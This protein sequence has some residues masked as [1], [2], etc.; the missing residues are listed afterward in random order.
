MRTTRTCGRL[1]LTVDEAGAA[2][3]FF[4]EGDEQWAGFLKGAKA[5][6][7][8]GGGVGVAVDG[9]IGGDDE[10][11]LVLEARWRP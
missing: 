1:G 6:V 11:V 9:G 4:D 5:V 3:A 10:H 8:A 7:L 2:P